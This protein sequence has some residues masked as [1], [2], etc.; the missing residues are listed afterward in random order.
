M[1]WRNLDLWFLFPHGW[2]VNGHLDGFLIIGDYDGPESAVFGVD[3]L[4]IDG[5][6]PV[7]HQTLLIPAEKD[8]SRYLPWI[9]LIDLFVGRTCDPHQSETGTILSSGWFPTTWSM[10]RKCPGGLCKTKKTHCEKFNAFESWNFILFKLNCMHFW[11]VKCHKLGKRLHIS[12][13]LAWDLI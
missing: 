12:M 13:F 2:F 9:C 8:S 10:K 4:I 1:C 3:L 6:E 11:L 5:P 7:E